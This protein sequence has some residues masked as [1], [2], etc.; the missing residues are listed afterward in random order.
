MAN[1]EKELDIPIW[2]KTNLTVEEAA[3]YTGIG[4]NKLRELSDS[5]SCDFVLWISVC[6]VNGGKFAPAC[7]DLPAWQGIAFAGYTCVHIGSNKS[8]L[9]DIMFNKEVPQDIQL[10]GGKIVSDS[11]FCIDLIDFALVRIW[12]ACSHRL[13]NLCNLLFFGGDFLFLGS[14]FSVDTVKRILL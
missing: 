14:N 1:D 3:A 12:I 4:M 10:I 11:Q 6:H 8:V 2:L 9:G 13:L 7:T 5:D